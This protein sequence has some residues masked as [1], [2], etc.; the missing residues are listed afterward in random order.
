MSSSSSFSSPSNLSC[1]CRQ[2]AQVRIS[3][4]PSNPGKKFH[5]CKNWNNGGCNFFRWEDEPD[6][7]NNQVMANELIELRNKMLLLE[8]ENQKMKE[9]VA[10]QFQHAQDIHVEEFSKIR[11]NIWKL[12]LFV[13]ATWVMFIIFIVVVRW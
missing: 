3:K 4:T 6:S 11:Q 5:G 8:A 9:S 1:Y 10:L 2:P 7:S 12:E 13:V